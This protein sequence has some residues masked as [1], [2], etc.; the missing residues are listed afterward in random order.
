MALSEAK[1][2][3]IVEINVRNPRSNDDALSSFF[4]ERYGLKECYVA[5]TAV[6]PAA[7]KRADMLLKL[8]AE[9]AADVVCNHLA[10]DI[11]IGIAWG[12]TCY[13]FMNSYTSRMAFLNVHV[14]PL[15]GGSNRNQKRFH[16]NEMVR[17]F[18]E[19]IPATPHF[20]HAPALADSPED[21]DL[22]MR[23]S[24][25]K[26]IVDAWNRIDLAIISIGAPPDSQIEKA[27]GRFPG[28]D[29]TGLVK[30][31]DAVGDI[32]GRFFD[33]DGKFIQGEISRRT[34]GISPE[35]LAE[36]RKVICLVSGIE[37]SRSILG[38]LKTNIIDIL[39]TDEITAKAVLNSATSH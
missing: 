4:V 17:A 32:C 18:S 39:I 9:R 35:G 5:P 36:A 22:Y 16:L 27:N 33:I 21:Y 37:K 15:I 13:Q 6:A 14:Y 25:L 2:C 19:K 8:T 10:D 38:A 23:S 34:I 1:D 11:S 12:L 30:S 31:T 3:G 7:L 29:F 28:N 20:I 26:T 24:S